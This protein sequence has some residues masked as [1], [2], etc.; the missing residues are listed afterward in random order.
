MF[1]FFFLTDAVISSGPQLIDENSQGAEG[2]KSKWTEH[3]SPD[4]RTYYYNAVTKQSLWEKPDELKTPA[5]VCDK[6]F[7]LFFK[8]RPRLL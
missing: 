6:M 7:P 1:F 4:G 5:E 3:S 2:S 8:T